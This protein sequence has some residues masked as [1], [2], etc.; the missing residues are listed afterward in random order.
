MVAGHMT[1]AEAARFIRAAYGLVR[2]ALPTGTM[3]D[4]V[5]V[6]IAALDA[7]MNALEDALGVEPWPV[8]PTVAPRRMTWADVLPDDYVVAP[9]GSSYRVTEAVPGAVT[10]EIDGREAAFSRDPAGPVDVK[11]GPTGQAVDVFAAAGFSV[12]RIGA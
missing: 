7:L 5:L 2:D 8:E 1:E 12:E 10:L 9:N 4:H 6:D 3:R 11:R